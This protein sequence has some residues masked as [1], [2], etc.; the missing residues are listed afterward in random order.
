MLQNN[1]ILIAYI[2][3]FDFLQKLSFHCRLF[4]M[5][6]LRRT[7]FCNI[8]IQISALKVN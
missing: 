8:T 5:M 3:N 7:I 4:I 1:I 2:T 6:Y